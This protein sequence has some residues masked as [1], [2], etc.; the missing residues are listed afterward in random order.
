MEIITATK[1]GGAFLNS[2]AL[3]VRT[4]NSL[5]ES[6]LAWDPGNIDRLQS[7]EKLLRPLLPHVA[8][9]RTFASFTYTMV[10]LALGRLDAYVHLGPELWDVQS[11]LIV[12]EA[13]GMS[14]DPSG[15]PIDWANWAGGQRRP[16]IASNGTIHQSIIEA[17]S[18]KQE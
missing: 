13:G 2:T 9:V 15:N 6:Q 8:Y 10:L 17:I 3:H 11:D 4:S 5:R 7:M 14:S 12:Q 16:Y 18:S 1:D